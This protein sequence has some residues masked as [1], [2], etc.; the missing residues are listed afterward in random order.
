MWDLCSN[1]DFIHHSGERDALA[2]VLLA[3]EPCDCPFD[4]EPEAAVR[5]RAVFSQVQIPIVIFA[6][7]PLL[8]D[9]RN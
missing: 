3:R 2:D 4:A 5:D 1:I 6:L 7:E 8:L 9:P